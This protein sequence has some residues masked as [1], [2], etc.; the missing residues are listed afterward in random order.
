MI[1]FMDMNMPGE[2]GRECN[3][4]IRNYWTE[5]QMRPSTKILL[6]SAI[7]NLQDIS[8]I[9]QEFNG[10]ADKPIHLTRLRELIQRIQGE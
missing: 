3:R 9:K 2:N 8:A 10:V 7:G 1:I 4:R 5:H 6:H